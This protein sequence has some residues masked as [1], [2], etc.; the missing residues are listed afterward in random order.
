[1]NS[2]FGSKGFE[3]PPLSYQEG[4]GLIDIEIMNTFLLAKWLI[5]F[6][7]AFI[8]GKWKDI[9]QAKYKTLTISIKTSFFWKAMLRDKDLI[10]L[11]F[12]K[13]LV[14][15]N[16]IFFWTDRWFEGCALFS[17][18]PLLYSI[19][20]KPN[21][22]IADAYSNG[23]LTLDFRRQLL[24]HYLQEWIHLHKLVGTI[25]LNPMIHDICTWRWH[26]SCVFSVHFFYE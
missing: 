17:S 15:D 1:L 6:N 10:E 13:I 26:P 2:L 19:I 23:I 12:N 18:Y 21:I 5:R 9:I 16:N 25:S 22:T 14:S 11:G 4:L 20:V 3:P 24:G 7:D 8:V